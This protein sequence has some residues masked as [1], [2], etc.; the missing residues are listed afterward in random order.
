MGLLSGRRRDRKSHDEAQPAM[1][2][3]RKAFADLHDPG[4]VRTARIAWPGDEWSP[5]PRGR[6]DRI[7][8]RFTLHNVMSSAEH[9]LATH[10]GISSNESK[11]E[12]ARI[13]A[14]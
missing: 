10:S 8:T 12:E 7:G 6:T 13:A 14:F 5:S 11:S 3:A 9:V 4:S 1:N 2:P